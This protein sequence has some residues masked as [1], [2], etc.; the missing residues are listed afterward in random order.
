M[1]LNGNGDFV[2]IQGAINSSVSGDTIIAYPGTYFENINY[3]GKNILLASLVH[4]IGNPAYRD[5]TIIEAITQD[6][7]LG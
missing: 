4:S 2:T 3:S 1:K 7:V 5:S 6:P